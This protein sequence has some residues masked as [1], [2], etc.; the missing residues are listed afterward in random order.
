MSVGAEAEWVPMEFSPQRDP[1]FVRI[2][3]QAGGRRASVS[4]HIWEGTLPADLPVGGHLIRI[5]TVDMYGQEY[6]ASRIVRVK[7]AVEAP[8]PTEESSSVSG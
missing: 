8:D 3:E 5:R 6:S 1:L 4:T 2:S 7:E